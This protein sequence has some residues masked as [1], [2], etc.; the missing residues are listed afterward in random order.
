MFKKFYPTIYRESVDTIDFEK[1]RKQGYRALFFDIDNTLV[2]HDAPANEKAIATIGS[3]KELGYEICLISNNH[4]PRVKS[5]AD[6]VGV[7]YVFEAGKPSGRGYQS[8][9]KETS[10]DTENSLFIGDQLFTDIWGANNAGMKS[11]LV[12]PLGPDPTWKLKM[13]RIGEKIVLPCYKRY[14]G[15]HPETI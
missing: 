3:L 1:Y 5:F 13:K 7:K 11:I 9:M 14:A 12:K 15:K 4:E 6:A 8:A 2:G 10:S